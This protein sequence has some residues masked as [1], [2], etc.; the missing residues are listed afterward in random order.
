MSRNCTAEAKTNTARKKPARQMPVYYNCNMAGHLARDCTVSAADTEP[1]K[2]NATS[3]GRDTSDRNR[4]FRR[5]QRDRV[6]G[7]IE[8]MGNRSG[9][10]TCDRE[11]RKG[12]MTRLGLIV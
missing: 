4:N 5:A 7:V 11:V 1:T 12:E 9:L 2:D 8:I 3:K 10:R 6:A